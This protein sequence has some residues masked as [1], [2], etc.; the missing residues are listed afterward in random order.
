MDMLRRLINCRII[1]IIIIIIIIVTIL[2]YLLLNY[3]AF[4]LWPFRGLNSQYRPIH[5]VTV[6]TCRKRSS[7]H[8]IPFHSYGLSLVIWDHSVTC[9]PTQVKTPRLNPS[10]TGR[11]AGTR[12]TYHGGMEGWVDLGCWLLTEMVYLLARWMLC[13]MAL[14]IL[15]MHAR[16]QY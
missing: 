15:L 9:H 7:L 5:I 3:T 16:K 10:Q 13:D 11:L 6:T 12:F 14:S 8:G 4:Q 1:I 2:F